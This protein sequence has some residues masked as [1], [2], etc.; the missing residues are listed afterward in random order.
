MLPHCKKSVKRIKLK[1]NRAKK[2]GQNK[3]LIN[4]SKKKAAK[5]R[6]FACLV[7]TKGLAPLAA[8]PAERIVLFVLPFYF[9]LTNL[10][11]QNNCLSAIN[12]T[13]K[14]LRIS[15]KKARLVTNVAKRALVRTKGLEPPW[16]PTRT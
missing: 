3:L 6:F 13:L 8:R 2:L 4:Q 10:S 14:S 11:R 12:S 1:N 5:C 9:C 15:R 16:L 7:R